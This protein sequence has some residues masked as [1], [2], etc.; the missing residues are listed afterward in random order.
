LRQ[1][2][3]LLAAAAQLAARRVWRQLHHL[4]LDELGHQ[5]QLDW[6]RASWTA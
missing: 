4:L 1:P 2:G 6:S 5:G 3:H